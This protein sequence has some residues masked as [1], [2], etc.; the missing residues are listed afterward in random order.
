MAKR[1]QVKSKGLGDTV[2]KITEATGIDK[3]VKA[4]AGED[5]GCLERQEALNRLFPY[6]EKK[7]CMTPEQYNAYI[8]FKERSP[9]LIDQNDQ[10]IILDMYNSI[11]QTN[12]TGCTNCNG[13]AW[14]G[15]IARLDVIYKNYDQGNSKVAKG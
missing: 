10:K 7:N 4:I 12:I 6:N 1:K 8:D 9:K 14:K 13:E 5:C 15:Y 3:V 2:A 11:F